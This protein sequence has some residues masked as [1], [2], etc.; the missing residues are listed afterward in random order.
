MKRSEWILRQQDVLAAVREERKL[1]L[2]ELSKSGSNMRTQFHGIMD[3]S[4]VAEPSTPSERIGAWISK[5]LA[6]YEGLR[7]GMTAVRTINSLFGVR[8]SRRRR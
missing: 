5:G 6:V 1:A 7:I 2:D 8:K 4:S 3:P